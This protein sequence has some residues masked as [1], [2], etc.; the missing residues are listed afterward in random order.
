[1]LCPCHVLPLLEEF[2]CIVAQQA[3]AITLDKTAACFAVHG[4]QG[5]SIRMGTRHHTSVFGF[6]PWPHWRMPWLCLICYCNESERFDE[7][8][9][10]ANDRILLHCSSNCSRSTVA[11]SD[12]QCR[13]DLNFSPSFWMT[14]TLLE[15]YLQYWWLILSFRADRRWLLL[16]LFDVDRL[17]AMCN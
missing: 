10:S 7:D 5:S 6:F 2:D 15:W 3:K 8:T 16:F 4:V 12:A 17:L 1:M 11:T 9:S 14:L 13:M